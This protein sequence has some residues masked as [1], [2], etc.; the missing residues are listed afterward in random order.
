MPSILNTPTP[1]LEH[2]SMKYNLLVSLCVIFQKGNYLTQGPIPQRLLSFLSLI[3]QSRKKSEWDPYPNPK[4]FQSQYNSRQGPI[5]HPKGWVGLYG[6]GSRVIPNPFI[7]ILILV[8]LL[9]DKQ[10]G[11]QGVYW[12]RYRD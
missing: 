10:S 4:T 8:C 1:R 7:H 11:V 5:Q 6:G 2:E 9:D 12:E 3:F